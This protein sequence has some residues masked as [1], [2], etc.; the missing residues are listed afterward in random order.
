VTFTATV[1]STTAGTITGTVTFL[2]GATS[3]G[4]G[5][6]ASGKATLMTSSL[7]AGSHSITAQYGGDANYATS[8]S[9]ALT[10]VVNAAG[11]T[12]TT[13]ALTGPA[14]GTPGANLTYTATVTPASGTKVP[15]GMANFFDGATNI[16]NGSLNGS[17]VATFSTTVLAAGMHSITAQYGGDN[18]FSGSTSNAVATT[19][20][21]PAGSF[22][23]SVAPTSVNVTAAKPGTATVTVTPTSGFNQAVQFS[24]TN[25]PEGIDCEFEPGS[26]TPNAGPAT[27]MLSVTE[28]QENN[29]ARGRK[30]GI[31][32]WWTGGNHEGS[33]A[34]IKLPFA[35]ALGIELMALAGLWRRKQFAGGRGWGAAFA[36]VLLL[37][38]ATFAGG[39]SGNP[40]GGSGTTTITVV[41]TGPGGATATASLNVTIQK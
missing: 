26:V 27:T 20:A 6:L 35:F 13:T 14:T 32:H 7:A 36:V 23:I 40:G 15:T 25:V 22:T 37:T 39:C 2:D 21:A 24:C 30:A 10:Q 12:G 18:N 4:M 33:G 19:I 29:G 34:R 31:G 3:L 8:T 17:G 28:G 9:P 41:G 5:T 11:L 16:G 38:V 1:T